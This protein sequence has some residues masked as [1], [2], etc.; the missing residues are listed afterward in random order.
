MLGSLPTTLF[1]SVMHCDFNRSTQ[2]TANRSGSD[3]FHGLHS[4]VPHDLPL[5][6]MVRPRCS[7]RYHATALCLLWLVIIV[8]LVRIGIPTEYVA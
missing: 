4:N 7:L 3:R 6:F 1:M 8:L 5:G 2:H